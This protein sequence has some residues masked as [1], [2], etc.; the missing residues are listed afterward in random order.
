MRKKRR[1]Y[2]YW[3]A[4]FLLI[5]FVLPNV[6]NFW[7]QRFFSEDQRLKEAKKL[8][9]TNRDSVQIIPGEYYKR[10]SL[11]HFFFGKKNRDMWTA[12]VN[13]KVLHLDSSKGGLSPYDIGGSQQT[14]SVKLKD[15]AGKH[16]VIRSVNKDQQNAL[17]KI[18]RHTALR[19]MFR[20]QVA[21][22]NPYAPM[23]AASLAESAQLPHCNPELFWMP[24]NEKHGKYNQK[25]AGRLVYLEE[26]YD[27][28][29]H[30][31][32]YNATDIV[33]TDD[34]LEL[35][36]KKKISI[37]TI[38]YLKNRLFDMLICDWDR[39][40]GQWRWALID[41]AGQKRFIPIAKDRDMAMY[42]FDEGILSHI[43]LAVNN[44]FQ[45]FRNEIVSV[46]GLMHQAK[47]LDKKIL[48]GVSKEEFLAA[49]KQLQVQINA[50]AIEMAFLY[51]PS[52]IK[53]RFAPRHQ[54]ILLS[55]LQK[56][57]VVAE[58]FYKLVND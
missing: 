9:S 10:G 20:D 46:D 33:D 23:I 6:I 45:S 49:V 32:L 1:K 8:T 42:V 4:A 39:H 31:Q 50:A 22:M 27:T 53:Q 55:R 43:T 36:R 51:Y 15:T 19:F 26:N 54:Q 34:M 13:V 11:H 21:S 56:M 14:I 58:E 24:Y 44:K 12:P 48:Q 52:E 47:K 41:S 25:I 40:E 5:F 28:T 57:P 18:L 2:L 37:D 7:E 35:Q 17:P 38:L 30:N 3:I 16:W 29:W